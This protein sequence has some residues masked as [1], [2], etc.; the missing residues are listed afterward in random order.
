MA[1]IIPLF[2]E[3]L[4]TSPISKDAETY[5][6]AVRVAVYDDAVSG[7]ARLE[8][9][10]GP[11]CTACTRSPTRADH[12]AWLAAVRSARK[13]GTPE[14]D[15]PPQPLPRMNELRQLKLYPPTCKDP[16]DD[17]LYVVLSYNDH[18]TTSDWV[19]RQ[20]QTYGWRGF[21]V[22]DLALKCG[23]DKAT[24]DQI[25]ACAPYIA[26]GIRETGAK[27]VL[28]CGTAASKAVCGNTMHPWNYGSWTHVP[29]PDKEDGT[30]DPGRILVV[31]APDPA[32]SMRNRFIKRLFGSA[33]DRAC[34]MGIPE[35]LPTDVV[36]RVVLDNNDLKDFKQWLSGQPWVSY[37]VEWCGIPF[38]KDFEVVALA[39]SHPLSPIVWVFDESLKS[40][41]IHKFLQQV[42]TSVPIVAQN[43]AAEFVATQCH[44]GV[45]LERI[46]G[47]T[48]LA[49]KL[50]NVDSKAALE[51]IAYYIGYNSHKREM[52][53]EYARHKQMVEEKYPVDLGDAS[54]KSFIMR[55]VNPEIRARYNALDTFITGEMHVESLKRLGRKQN[56]F[57]LGTYQ[58]YILPATKLFHRVHCN[59][60][61]VDQKLLPITRAKLQEKVESI[62]NMLAENHGIP[63][64]AKVSNIK[65]YIREH[66]L[67][68]TLLEHIAYDAQGR[69]LDER[70]FE[71]KKSKYFSRK[72]QEMSTGKLTL[73]ALKE[74]DGGDDG[75]IAAVLQYRE[76]SKLL[77]SYGATLHTYIRDDGRVH[78]RYR[79]DGAASGRT[80]VHGTTKVLTQLGEI[81]IQDLP[82]IMA[83]GQVVEVW[84]HQQ[85]WMPVS[86]VFTKG[87]EPMVH[88]KTVCGASVVCT[89]AHLL[90]AGEANGWTSSQLL[91]VGDELPVVGYALPYTLVTSITPLKGEHV[92]WDMTVPGDHSYTAQGLVHHNS[93]TSPN[94]QQVPK[95]GENST[96]IKSLFCAPFGWTLIAFDY[97]TLEVFVAAII[98]GDEAMMAACTSADFHLET[99]K[100]MAPF[101]W[102]CTPEQV[103]AEYKAGDKRK[104]SAAKGITF[105]ILY[106]AGAYALADTLKCTVEQ[107]DELIKAYFTAYPK[108]AAWV[109]A[110][111]NFAREFGYVEVPWAMQPARIRP[112]WHVGYE[113]FEE[114]HRMRQAL[115]QA[116]N[117][118]V[119]GC[120]AQFAI[121]AA[122]DIEEQ[123]RKQKMLAKVSALVHDS[124]I[125][126][127][128][129]SI[130]HDVI[131]MMYHAMTGIDTGS[132][133]RL[134]VDAEVGETW[135]SMEKID[136]KPYVGAE[137]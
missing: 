123:F 11:G 92:V 1:H 128:H 16:I 80:C 23:S 86:Q 20:V 33:V 51:D 109:K 69:K 18:G 32:D 125:V 21:V 58:N 95:H 88:V 70:T 108:F 127:A 26:Y 29:A 115:R 106:G 104:R 79:L 3:H 40:Q 137:S 46:E 99:A 17:V 101:A 83:T 13:A 27:R 66:G 114:K 124:I 2:P 113:G 30:P 87:V 76:M 8:C 135:G 107:A 78:P 74:L 44:F 65:E 4:D 84:T 35:E 117:T 98:S 75:G 22:V 59:G 55:H 43:V 60:M 48:M 56:A 25:A 72:T 116:Q 71:L 53:E 118:P 131:V 64:P 63:D 42:L 129:K 57:L 19:A 39:F 37:D 103:E 111:H 67:F 132:P 133:L 90:W 52:N 9:F 121:V 24:D 82:A 120:A 136:L 62:E 41:V 36:G 38:M 100:K 31:S 112:L 45:E 85:R 91:A 15:L 93:A 50:L 96:L 119:Q 5:D 47:D 102:K 77:S 130:V 81:A 89:H 97:K 6:P 105:S 54:Y 73:K 110:I 10:R 34:R 49:Y 122:M 126:E 61:L 68:D 134:Q 28:V 7:K 94:P 12:R 14:A